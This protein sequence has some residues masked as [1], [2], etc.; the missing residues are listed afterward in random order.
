MVVH[1]VML[2]VA[3]LVAIA[4]LRVFQ[5]IY[6]TILSQWELVGLDALLVVRKLLLVVILYFQASQVWVVVVLVEHQLHLQVG[7]VE[8][9]VA[10]TG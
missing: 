10:A 6:K 3:V 4:L 8:V 5:Y 1:S 2:E 7:L 9:E